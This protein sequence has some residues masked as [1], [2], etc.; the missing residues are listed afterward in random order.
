LTHSINQNKLA[1]NLGFP[2]ILY[3]YARKLSRVK[4]T[5]WFIF[6]VLLAVSCL[7]EPDCF[8]LN[9]NW[10]GISFKVLGSSK[11]DTV[12]LWGVGLSG[13]VTPFTG[14]DTAISSG[15]SVPL[16][17]YSDRTM[18]NF[19]GLAAD[20][21]MTLSYRV[22]SQFVSEECG[23]RFVLSGL[24]IEGHDFDSARV[25]NSTPGA[26]KNAKNIEVYRCPITNIVGFEYRQLFARPKSSQA[27]SLPVQSIM[28]EYSGTQFYLNDTISTF[29]LL[30]NTEQSTDSTT[31]YTFTNPDNSSGS[32]ILS[33][34]ITPETRYNV[35]GLQH[36]VSALTIN[37]A[38]T[39]F[40]SVSVV[41]DA[42]T[43]RL[44]TTLQDPPVTNVYLFRCPDTNLARIAFR[45]VVT[46]GDTISEKVPLKSVRS[47][48]FADPI[49]YN[50]SLNLLTVPLDPATDHT[51][52]YLDYDD[53]P[54]DT[55]RLGYNRDFPTLFNA[56]GTQTTFR[57][58]ITELERP[59][60]IIKSDSVQFPAITNL[61]IVH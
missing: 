53:R 8:N 57:D 19:D 25:V 48:Y 15:V 46:P 2:R 12:F 3:L 26:S 35:C 60:T 41:R 1:W 31:T 6:F 40:D 14:A 24:K 20:R 56:C 13:S 61:E 23:S 34:K 4:R 10:V 7:D 9:N 11:A 16:N 37:S 43:Q 47:T 50:T 17:I 45:K 18:I 27:V 52:F 21:T 51:I 49:N 28:A 55:L 36:F 32:L 33:Y 39:A 44:Q 22:Q 58:L 30:V 42:T 38:S 5:S 54:T 29:Y 59:F